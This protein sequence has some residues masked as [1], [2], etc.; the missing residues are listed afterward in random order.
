MTMI[1]ADCPADACEA[2]IK[3]GGGCWREDGLKVGSESWASLGAVEQQRPSATRECS[4]MEPGN[5]K[6][7][8]MTGCRQVSTRQES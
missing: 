1:A 2:V 4:W 6:T 8:G 5:G 7:E 3:C